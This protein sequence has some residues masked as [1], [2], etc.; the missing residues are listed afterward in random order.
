MQDSHGYDAARKATWQSLRG[1]RG[2]QVARVART[3]GRRPRE[4]TQTPGWCHVV[5]GMASEGP[6]G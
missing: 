3:R 1:P 2:A 6:T 4:P 5:G